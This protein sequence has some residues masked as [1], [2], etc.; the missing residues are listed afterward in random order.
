MLAGVA[1]GG[2][3]I[4]GTTAIKLVWPEAIG[5]PAPFLLYFCSV[6][7][8]AWFGGLVA[9]LVTATAAALIGASVF[10]LGDA[11]AGRIV[12]FIL[13]GSAIALVTAALRR[14]QH[15][16]RTSAEDARGLIGKLH[17]VIENA[18]DAITVQDAS[19]RVIFANQKAAAL[20]GFATTNQLLDADPDELARRYQVFDLDG[21]PFPYSELPARIVLAGGPPTRRVMRFHDTKSGADRLADVRATP[22]HEDGRLR[23]AVNVLRDVTEERRFQ[24]EARLGQEWFQTALR[25]IGDAVIATD[26]AG[27]VKFANPVAEALTGWPLAD[28]IGHPLGDVFMIVDEDTGAALPSPIDQV[29]AG[30]TVVTLAGHTMLVRR[31]GT[32]LAIADSAAPI[33]DSDG[34]L[35]GIV[36]VFRDVSVERRNAQRKAFL[37]SA[38]TEM[39]SSL[40]YEATLATVARLAVPAIADWAAVDVVEGDHLRRLGIAH[41]DPAKLALVAEIERRFPPDP[42]APGGTYQVA[43]SGK[44]VLVQDITPEMIRQAVRDPEH[45]ALLEGLGLRSYLAVPLATRGTTLG[46]FTLAMAESRR[47][48]DKADL[49]LALALATRAAVAID[50]ARLFRD[51]QGAR[52]QAEVASRAKDEFLAM[53]GHE[54]RN[55]LAPIV[56]A[57]ELLNQRREPALERERTVIERQVRHLIRLVDDL[58]DVSRITRGRIE[59]DRQPVALA[60]AVQNALEMSE[61]LIDQKGHSVE[62]DVPGDLVVDADAV[63]LAQIIANLVTNA[64]KY[65]E[66]GGHIAIRARRDG[67]RI[68][69]AVRDNGIGI[70]PA[71]LPRVF[72]MF[73]QE[74]QA[75]DRARGG[76]GLGL[77]IVKSLVQLHG[78]EVTAHSDGPGTGSEFRVTLPASARVAVDARA[79][80]AA[81]SI[82]ERHA[83]T[84]VL[85]VDDNI[86]AGDILADALEDQGYRVVRAHDGP[87]AIEAAGAAHPSIVLLDIGLPVMDG[88]EVGRRLRAL[89]GLADIKLV[90]I[91]GYGQPADK[92][93]STDA[94]FVAHLVKPIR[95]AMLSS[96][97]DAIAGPAV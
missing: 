19:G 13:E 7:L 38:T 23:Y 45:S 31:D 82:V 50:N 4:A 49:D 52:E 65:T 37:A 42:E 28:A 18:G 33:R 51:A 22:I 55:P 47:R 34:A 57:I 16:A 48:Y 2:A 93:R 78:G 11:Q 90:A 74:P 60:R 40:D 94:G 77:T 71:V 27:L 41:R 44:P 61:G 91:T 56:T 29:V 79:P 62:V 20:T 88:Y 12:V 15:R 76:L 46:V 85:V 3:L 83:A 53:L 17:A 67:D 25:S 97:L 73:V 32:E 5:Y 43:R 1:M 63:R 75:A 86:D 87:S 96:T 64:A 95:L 66:P 21:K 9:G 80:S 26:A 68:T 84:T 14:S 70:A 81:D 54:L 6:A 39:A 58:L 10:M 59:L 30:G 8:A 72:D 36:V 24:E 35:A 89:P 92:Q 69:L